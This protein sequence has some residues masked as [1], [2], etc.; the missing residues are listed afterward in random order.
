V[1]PHMRRRGRGGEP[2]EGNPRHAGRAMATVGTA[3]ALKVAERNN[4]GAYAVERRGFSWIELPG[5]AATPVRGGK[6]EETG[7][8]CTHRMGRSARCPDEWLGAARL[9]RWR[10]PGAHNHPSVGTMQ[11]RADVT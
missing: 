9:G 8:T 3:L 6:R 10:A 11:D 1:T 4:S 5:E 2:V 7:S